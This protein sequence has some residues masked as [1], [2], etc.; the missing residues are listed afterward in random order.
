MENVAGN[1]NVG[2]EIKPSFNVRQKYKLFWFS[3]GVEKPL[4]VE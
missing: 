4:N 3:G 1:G 2:I